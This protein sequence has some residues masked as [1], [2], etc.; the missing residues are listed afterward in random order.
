MVGDLNRFLRGWAAY[1]RY[2]NSTGQFDWITRYARMR[3]AIFLAK[4]N[5]RSRGFG[6]YVVAFAS[7]DQLALGSHRDE[8]TQLRLDGRAAR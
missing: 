1:F 8:S 3:L 6:W 7:P 4:R 5:R 2:G